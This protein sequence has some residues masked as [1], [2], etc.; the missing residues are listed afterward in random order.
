MSQENACQ[1]AF[2]KSAAGAP[3]HQQHGGLVNALGGRRRMRQG[4]ARTDGDDTREG[5]RFRP[6]A[7]HEEFQIVGQ[8][9]FHV[10]WP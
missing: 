6:G 3:I 8:V 5:R 2:V 1:V 4:G 10:V 7:T 9:L